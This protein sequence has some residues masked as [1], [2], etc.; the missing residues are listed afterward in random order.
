MRLFLDTNIFIIGA[1]EQTSPEADILRWLGYYGGVGADAQLIVCKELLEQILRVGRRV[2]GKD[3][4][5]ALINRVWR[6]LTLEF[7]AVDD[8]EVQR[9]LI[10]GTVPREDIEIFLAAIQGRV[11]YFVSENRL[12]VKAA[13][14]EHTLFQSYTAEAFC[15]EVLGLHP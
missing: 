8:E 1:V 10:K 15:G 5:G 2:G 12:L 6:T 9:L 7:V 13:G 4:A 3:F 11:D 14:E